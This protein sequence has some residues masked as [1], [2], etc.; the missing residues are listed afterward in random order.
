MLPCRAADVMEADVVVI[1]GGAT[2][3]GIAWDLSLRGLSVVL[4]EKGD[5]CGG[6]SGRYHGLLHSGARYATSD[7]ATARDCIEENA[8]VRAIAPEAVEDTGGIFA[9]LPG[10][11]VAYVETWVARIAGLP[12]S[13]CRS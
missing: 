13:R 5:I 6:T 11:D 12:A 9:L 3:T 7:L 2:G 1:G 8:I 4:I 10:D